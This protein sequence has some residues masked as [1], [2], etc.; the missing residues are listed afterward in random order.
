MKVARL[1][2]IF[3]A[4]LSLTVLATSISGC[5][6]ETRHKVLTFFFTG[7]P[8]LEE[9]KKAEVE[10]NKSAK[11][12]RPVRTVVTVYTHP[13]TA[14]NRCE[15]C[16]QTTA[17]F[18]LFGRRTRTASFQKGAM[19]PGPL[20]MDRKELCVSCHKNKSAPEA[21]AAGLW[22]HDTAAKGDCYACHD[23]HQSQHRY[24]LLAEPE[25][26]CI[27]CH[28]ETEMM[29]KVK[30][31]EAHRLPSDCLTCHNPHLGKDRALLTKDYKEVKQTAGP[32]PGVPS[33]PELPGKLPEGNSAAEMK[34]PPFAR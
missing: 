19:S 20:V 26:I 3:I 30:D 1:R 5:S 33:S 28:K 17:N 22:L 16:H 7:V 2:R 32:I 29:D 12:P 6:K 18:S 34:E 4:M 25:Q 8:P 11:E 27:P 13:V 14:A 15:V 23:P 9:E 24:L 31:K 10:K 21:L